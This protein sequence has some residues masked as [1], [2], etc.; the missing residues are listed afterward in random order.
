MNMFNVNEY[1]NE[2]Q[3][4]KDDEDLKQVKDLI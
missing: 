1:V 4:D 2:L 3:V